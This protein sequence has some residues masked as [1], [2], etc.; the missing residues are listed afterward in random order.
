MVWDVFCV[1]M[2]KYSVY[3]HTIPSHTHIGIHCWT[4]EAKEQ[5]NKI[6]LYIEK[7]KLSVATP[8]K[9]LIFLLRKKV[10]MEVVGKS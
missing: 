6:D 5:A 10:E 3:A 4:G 2:H 1:P 9:L 7:Q 8:L